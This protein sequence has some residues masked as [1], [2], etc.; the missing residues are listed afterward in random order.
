MS[1]AEWQLIRARETLTKPGVIQVVLLFLG[2]LAVAVGALLNIQPLL[3]AFMP[4]ELVALVMYGIRIG[5]RLA[6]VQWSERGGAR[7]FALAAPFLVANLGLLL[8]LIVGVTVTGAYSSFE[9]IPLWLIFAFDHTMFIGVMSNTLFGLIQEFT[10]A[11]KATWAFADDV[12]FYGMNIG[13]LGFVG[14]LVADARALEKV[15]TPIMGGSI[16]IGIVAYSLR[17]ARAP[18]LPT[19]RAESA[20]VAA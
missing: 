3:G 18:L 8:W 1:V 14:T 5:P 9:A 20:G 12:V 10:H 15:F 4:L 19:A 16:L 17:L 7:H 13:M 2:G 6:R 11:R